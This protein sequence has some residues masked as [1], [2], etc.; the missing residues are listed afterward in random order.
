MDQISDLEVL[1]TVGK[2]LVMLLHVQFAYRA[3]SIT[4]FILLRSVDAMSD[5]CSIVAMEQYN[6][7][8]IMTTTGNLC[9]PPS[10][11]L[12]RRCGPVMHHG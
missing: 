9:K 8:M 5:H 2:P 12:E 6:E 3:Y 1:V 10:L 4:M 11:A 7:G